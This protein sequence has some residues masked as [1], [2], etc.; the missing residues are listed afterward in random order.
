MTRIFISHAHSDKDIARKLVD[1]LQPALYLRD[2]QIRCT[3]LPGYKLPPGTS[4]SQQLKE[5]LGNTTALIAR[6][7][8]YTNI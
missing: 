1:F 2:E 4:I 5:D 8:L 3:S 7:A 6:S